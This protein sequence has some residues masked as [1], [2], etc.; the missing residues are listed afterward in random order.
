V[1]AAVVGGLP[2]GEGYEM[3]RELRQATPP[4]LVLALTLRLYPAHRALALEA[5]TEEV[6]AKADSLEEILAAV[7]R[8]WH[9]PVTP[10]SSIT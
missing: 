6:L 5:G 7:R 8:L 3:I 2:S 1:D 10:R 9:K 4:V